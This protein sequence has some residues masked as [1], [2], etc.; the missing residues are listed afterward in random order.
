MKPSKSEQTKVLSD[1]LEQRR[2]QL[3]RLEQECLRKM[4]QI[5]PSKIVSPIKA[6]S[7]RVVEKRST[8]PA[9]NLPH[10]WTRASTTILGSKLANNSS[11]RLKKGGNMDRVAQIKQR[12]K[13]NQLKS[14][15]GV[16]KICPA[17]HEKLRFTNTHPMACLRSFR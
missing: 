16:S 12:L 11:F 1:Q 17:K 13:V 9:V 14:P 4:K 6:V 5:T 7:S 2:K 8:Q 10:K 15:K 3:Q